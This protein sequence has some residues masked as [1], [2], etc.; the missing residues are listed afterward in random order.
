LLSRPWR[1]EADPA[2]SSLVVFILGEGFLFFLLDEPGEA[3]RFRELS[4]AC[5]PAAGMDEFREGA[6]EVEASFCSGLG[7]PGGDASVLGC[8]GRL[9]DASDIVPSPRAVGDVSFSE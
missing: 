1:F 6:A 8:L 2:S 9:D 4:G 3:L 5:E 7:G